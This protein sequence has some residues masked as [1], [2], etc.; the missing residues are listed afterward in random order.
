[1]DLHN[2]I[3]DSFRGIAVTAVERNE[4]KELRRPEGKYLVGGGFVKRRVD[5]LTN[6]RQCFRI[7]FETMRGCHD[8]MRFKEEWRKLPLIV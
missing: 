3:S 4:L 7:T 2:N 5:D 1:M 8:S 6:V